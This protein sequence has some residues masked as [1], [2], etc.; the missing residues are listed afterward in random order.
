MIDYFQLELILFCALYLVLY[1]IQGLNLINKIKCMALTFKSPPSSISSLSPNL[2][3]VSR[4]FTPSWGAEVQPNEQMITQESLMSIDDYDCALQLQ[5]P[6]IVI[7][8]DQGSGSSRTTR[9]LGEAKKAGGNI[10]LQ[11]KRPTRLVVPEFL[12]GDGEEICEKSRK[13][14]SKEFEVQGRDF[15][16]AAKKGRRR[17][18]MEDGYGVLLDI[19]GDPKQVSS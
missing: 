11:S 14:E 2:S 16:V 13:L 18:F 12:A 10:K 7:V 9:V 1:L 3:C 17:E 4:F 15:F 6:N 8:E 19:M 5:E